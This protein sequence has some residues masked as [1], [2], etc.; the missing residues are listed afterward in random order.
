MSS[1]STMEIYELEGLEQPKMEKINYIQFP[2]SRELKPIGFFNNKWYWLN[3]LG[4]KTVEN[5]DNLF[6]C[7]YCNQKVEDY[8]KHLEEYK[9]FICKFV[10]R[11]T[12][13][14]VSNRFHKTSYKQN[15]RLVRSPSW[16]RKR[17][18]EVFKTLK[19][20]SL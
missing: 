2:N 3:N 6:S 20:F 10:I 8:T 14:S 17:I 11:I 12:F 18:A 7:K 16:C 13:Y 4:S 5:Q 19:F 15:R 9:H 1:S